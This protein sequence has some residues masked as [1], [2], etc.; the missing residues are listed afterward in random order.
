MLTLPGDNETWG[1]G[2]TVSWG[3]HGSCGRCATPTA[4]RRWG[5]L[6]AGTRDWL[7][8]EPITGV[9]V[10]AGVEDR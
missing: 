8:G 9:S 1:G 3:D 10:M 4:G 2:I 7:D 6:P 5:A